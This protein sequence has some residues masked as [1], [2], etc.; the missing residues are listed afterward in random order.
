MSTGLRI[1]LW[2]V[3]IFVAFFAMVGVVVFATAGP[4]TRS[5]TSGV[6][7]P[8]AVHASSGPFTPSK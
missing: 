2:I 8:I 4:S 7:Y 1:V 6:R 3:F 5:G